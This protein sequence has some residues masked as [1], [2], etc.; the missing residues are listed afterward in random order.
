MKSLRSVESA[1]AKKVVRSCML[2][3]V[4]IAA[5][6]MSEARSRTF[7]DRSS[8]DIAAYRSA[9]TLAA[10]RIASCVGFGAR[11]KKSARC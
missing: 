2:A 10:R 3:A 8:T 11:A 6:C 7:V 1:F 5:R 4:T 9:V